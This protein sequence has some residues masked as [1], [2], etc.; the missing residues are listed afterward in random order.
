MSAG[1]TQLAVS[2]LSV[3]S[4]AG[5]IIRDNV[6][7]TAL[8]VDHMRDIPEQLVKFAHGLFYVAD[9]SLALDDQGFLEVNIGLVG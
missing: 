2:A 9:L 1:G 8:V 6:K 7:L 3:I 5:D 4:G